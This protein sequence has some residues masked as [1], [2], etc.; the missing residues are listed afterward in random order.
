MLQGCWSA[1]ARK[2]ILDRNAVLGALSQES[3]R[4]LQRKN[5]KRANT[6]PVHYAF[7]LTVHSDAVVDL[8]V[9]LTTNCRHNIICMLGRLLPR[10]RR[11]AIETRLLTFLDLSISDA[12]QV[13]CLAKQPQNSVHTV[14]T[15][16]GRHF[17]L[18]KVK[19]LCVGVDQ[20]ETCTS[21]K[22]QLNACS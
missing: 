19:V 21:L 8:L 16:S 14:R 13:S 6:K 9:P 1:S 10:Y 2:H 15:R 3:L 4:N 20:P 11:A 18:K 5:Q 22:W 17:N 7:S 12:L